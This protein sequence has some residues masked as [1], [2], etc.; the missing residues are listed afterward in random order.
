MGSHWME[1]EKGGVSEK[2]LVSCTL[3]HMGKLH[4]RAF[5]FSNSSP[6]LVKCVGK[7]TPS[8]PPY[9]QSNK[10]TVPWE[11]SFSW[12]PGAISSQPLAQNKTKNKK[13]TLA[14][15]RR[16]INLLDSV[17]FVLKKFIYKFLVFHHQCPSN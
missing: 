12:K 11:V 3:E 16:L 6:I 7:I 2:E 13:N 9:K 10:Q 5:L 17:I 15:W 8:P 4:T 14:L 1:E